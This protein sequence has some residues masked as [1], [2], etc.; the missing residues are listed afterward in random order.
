MGLQRAFPLPSPTAQRTPEEEGQQGHGCVEETAELGKACLKPES[1]S[2]LCVLWR[3]QKLSEW[4]CSYLASSV[5]VLFI[6]RDVV[7][8]KEGVA[9][10]SGPMADPIAFSQQTSLPNHV[11][12][13]HCVL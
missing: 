7:E 9:V 11:A 5:E 10:P 6:L 2:G 8:G 3:A 4:T 1:C 12:A 13:L